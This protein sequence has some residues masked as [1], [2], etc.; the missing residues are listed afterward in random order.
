ME[1][2]RMVMAIVLSCLVFLGYNFF[3]SEKHEPKMVQQESIQQPV[4]PKVQEKKRES[5][6]PSK[7]STDIEVSNT[8]SNP[9]RIITIEGPFYSVK[10]DTRGAVVKSVQLREYRETVDKDSP[11]KELISRENTMGT[12]KLELAGNSLPGLK[13]A[14]FA[15]ENLPEH[16]KISDQPIE[17]PF[18]WVSEQGVT[19]EKRYRFSPGSY[20][21]GLD[22]TLSNPSEHAI[23][24]SVTLSLLNHTAKGKSQY[25]FEGPSAL[26]ND[27]L[28]QIK[29]DS[30][31]KKNLYEGKI[32]WV[33]LQDRYFLTSIIPKESGDAG[34]QLNLKET[35]LLAATWVGPQVMVS[36]QQKKT[37]SFDVF[38]GPKKISV[39][40]S[41][42]NGLDRAVNFGWFDVI[43]RPFLWVMNFIHQMIPNY[44]V[45]IIILTI[46]IK[47]IL[48][49]LGQ[50]SYKSMNQMKRMQPLMTEIREKYKNDKQKINEETMALYRTYKVNPMGGCL[51]MVAQI[52]VFFA[53][54]RMLYEAI[55]L[56]HAPFWGWIND[57]SA[58][59]RL[60]HFNVSSIPFMEP[61]YGIPVLTIIM[62][63][64]MFIQ[65]KMQPPMGDPAQ[66]KMMMFMPVIFTVIFINFSS[67]LV[68]YWLV[69][70]ILSI[71]QQYFVSKKT[72]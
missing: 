4:T 46:L 23:Q 26:I 48:W 20:L 63:A 29:T 31:E 36:P 11:P 71:A 25:G 41:F 10:L 39:L 45:A 49:P 40:K 53:F 1:Q 24:D 58:P 2:F 68:L 27:K 69:N 17:V 54:Y 57:L 35:G 6:I 34:L 37:F 61:P 62:G 22:V 32:G 28:E 33:S 15:S 65:Q 21:I 9:E 42:G 72:A 44:G 70:N 47:A 7:V 3:F 60:F 8:S 14:I 50:K 30:I 18:T 51:P 55:E 12:L 66:A 56:R 13:G 67:G 59:D 19:V 5:D 16:L 64:T 52:P 38:F 43:A